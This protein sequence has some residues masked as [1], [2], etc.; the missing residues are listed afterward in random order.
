MLIRRSPQ[1]PVLLD[2]HPSND[3]S[4]PNRAQRESSRS[5]KADTVAWLVVVW[6]QIRSVNVT[7]LTSDVGHCKDNLCATLVTHSSCRWKESTYSFLLLGLTECRRRPANNDRV[8]RVRA[9]GENEA[10]YVAASGVERA[11]CDDEP[12]DCD[13]QTDCDVPCSLVHS[14][15]APTCQDTSDTSEDEWRTS[16]NE[17]DRA[18]E[19]KSLDNT[20]QYVSFDFR[21]QHSRSTKVKW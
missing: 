4:T 13:E 15:G 6:P 17:R 10:R 16:Q 2:Q 3:P 19:T 7:N 9:H 1:L 8:D 11:C 12:N 14:S 21:L 20:I 5:A 18:I